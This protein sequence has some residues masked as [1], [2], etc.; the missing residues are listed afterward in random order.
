MQ[1]HCLKNYPTSTR[2]CILSVTTAG[3][4]KLNRKLNFELVPAGCWKSNLRAVLSKKQWDYIK[5]DAKIRSGGKCSICGK[6]TKF[7]DA[8]E[9]WSYDIKKGV[10]KLDDVI[11]VC[12]DCH[13]A[14][15]IGRTSLVGNL[16]RAENHYLKVRDILLIPKILKEPLYI[17]HEKK[18]KKTKFYC[19]L[20]KGFEKSKYL[21]II[22]RIQKDLTE[23]IVTI[24]PNKTLK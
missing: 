18:G 5:K 23:Q 10:Q 16:E 21:R 12:K 2:F 13:S 20:R 8:H 3:V 6:K 4:C 17:G 14:I 19:G 1:F 7:L 11:S 24:Y 9:V 22:V 15:H